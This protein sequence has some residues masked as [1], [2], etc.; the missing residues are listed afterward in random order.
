MNVTPR[1]KR[2]LI[3][4]FIASFI[5]AFLMATFFVWLIDTLVPSLS[6][7]GGVLNTSIRFAS[8]I[9]LTIVG[10]KWLNNISLSIIN[11]VVYGGDMNAAAEE[12]RAALQRPEVAPTEQQPPQTQLVNFEIIKKPDT[13][14]AR[15]QGADIFE[16][17]DVIDEYG[18]VR[19]L[20]F[21]GTVD[22]RGAAPAHLA[23]G[24]LI[25]PPGILYK[26]GA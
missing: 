13:P 8:V 3:Y 22:L 5:N 14:V 19:R 20:T 1:L 24:T 2:V 17:M 23:E 25:L 21:D 6:Q 4:Q 16:W 7:E 12:A 11:M 10:A 18:E 9:I 26:F 15:Y